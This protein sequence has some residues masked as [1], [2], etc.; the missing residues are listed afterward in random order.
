V[1]QRDLDVRALAAEYLDVPVEAG[2]FFHLKWRED[3]VGPPLLAA[4]SLVMWLVHR[5]RPIGAPYGYVAIT[6]DHVAM[7]EFRWNPTVVHRGIALC[8]LSDLR[9]TAKDGNNHSID[10]YLNRQEVGLEASTYDAES[11]RVIEALRAAG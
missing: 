3:F 4:I 6:P 2:A 11:A 7:L 9:A 8:R 5:V 10:L 1:S